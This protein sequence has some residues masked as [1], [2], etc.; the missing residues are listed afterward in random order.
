MS[1]LRLWWGERTPREQQ[2][3]MVMFA[4]IGLILAW[5]VVVRP[6]SE[7]LDGAQLR[8]SAAVAELAQAKG[9]AEAA[10]TRS[11]P[12]VVPLPIDSLLSRAAAQAG[13]ANARI[14]AQGP[15]AASITIDAARPQALFGWIAQLEGQGLQLRSLSARA[16]QDRTLAVEASFRA[17]Q[18]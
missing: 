9:R 14:V 10:G 12:A 16:N 13:F 5:L 7:A 18:A 3:L 8:H 6:L 4:L 17:P 15:A 2:L 1:G 11:R